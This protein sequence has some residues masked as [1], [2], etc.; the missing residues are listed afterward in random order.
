ML[1][2]GTGFPVNAEPMTGEM[3][4]TII[5]SHGACV[6]AQSRDAV[7]GGAV[8]PI[9]LPDECQRH[10]GDCTPLSQIVSDDASSFICCGHNH[11]RLVPG[12]RFRV[13]W[14]NDTIKEMSDWS[15]RDIK[16]TL[17]VLVQ[18]LSA[19]ANMREAGNLGGV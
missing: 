19:D 15:E 2:A 4:S 1:R 9:K 12:D 17:S 6:A 13:C 14:F 16:D 8:M 7:G 10:R 5:A 3:T 11:E 18:A